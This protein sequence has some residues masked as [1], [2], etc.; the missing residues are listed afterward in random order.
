M[1]PL[2]ARVDLGAMPMK[3]HS[4]FPKSLALLK[5]HHQIVEYHIQNTRRKGVLPL[6]RDVVGVFYSSSRLGKVSSVTTDRSRRLHEVS[7]DSL[8]LFFFFLSFSFYFFFSFFPFPFIFF[9]FF[10]FPF[11]FFLFPHTLFLSS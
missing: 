9:S 8:S 7:D 10:P 2:W 6:F 4:A 11:I 1:L 3:E 5:L